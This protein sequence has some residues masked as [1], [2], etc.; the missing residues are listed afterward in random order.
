MILILHPRKLRWAGLNNLPKD[1]QLER[2]G[3]H[4]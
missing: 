1:T 4:F 3:T 2:G